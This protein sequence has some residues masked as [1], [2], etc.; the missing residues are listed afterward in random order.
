M[1]PRLAPLALLVSIQ[2]LFSAPP[3]RAGDSRPL[4]V[5]DL[6][7]LKDV[8]D[9]RLSPD[10]R[11]VAFTVTSLDADKDRANADVWLAPLG[12]GD[13]VRLT[14]GDRSETNPRFSPDGKWIAFLATRPEKKDGEETSQV[15]LLPR[16]GGEATRLTEFPGGVSDF[17]WSPDSQKLV[18]VVGDADSDPPATGADGEKKQKPI[19]TRRLQFKR[20]T[21]GYLKESRSHLRVFDVEKR[22]SFALTAGAFDD[23]SPAWS[24]DGTR[25]AFVSNRTLPDA[26]R[27]QDTN[28][29]LVRAA[30]GE[31]PRRLTTWP[32]EDRQPSFSPDGKSIVYVQ[33]SDPKD[34]W[35]GA[36]VVAVV[37]A[38]GGAPR[39]LTSSLDRNVLQPRFTPDG[40]SVLFLLEDGGNQHLARVPIEGGSV[41]RVVGGERETSA[42]DVAKDGA[43]VVLESSPG[44]PAEVSAVEGAGLRRLSHVNDEVLKGIR[45]GE[46]QRLRVKSRDGTPVDGFLVLPPDYKVG[47]KEPTILRIHGGPASQYST[48]FEME[49]QVLAGRGYAVVAANPRG[50][51]GYGTSFSRALWAEWGNPDFEDVMAALDQAIAQGVADPDR[52]GVGGWSYGGILTNYVITK[53]D[54]FKAA[55]SGAS[56]SN[57]LA[58]YGTDHYQYEYEVELGLPWKDRERWL[59]LS[60]PFFDVEK[61]NAPTLF[62]CGEKDMNV[63]LLN[64]E[65]MYQAVRRVG[66]VDTELVIYPGEWHGLK[67]PSFRKDRYE[68]YLAWYDHYLKPRSTVVP[69]TQAE[70]VSK[71][72]MALLSPPPPAEAKVRLEK[73]LE[74]ARVAF[75]QKPDDVEALLRVGRRTA[76][77]GRY[78]EAAEIYSRGLAAHP[79]DPRLLRHRGPGTSRCGTTRRPKPISRGRPSS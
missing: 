69:G 32:G 37:P 16:A 3:A 14:T 6:F 33:G 10:G 8:D 70:T 72:G 17:A 77:L 56:I 25:V 5:D 7:R 74:E 78:R 49:W 13:A 75:L 38:D 64:T 34:L 63:P 71:L 22:T 66:K 52:L 12:G 59:K 73:D 39:P 68:R 2:T 11:A 29:F 60:T 54:R 65:Q 50:S 40:R 20:D 24:P 35:Y 45:L 58:G 55:I 67:R 41:E 1:G 79:D 23:E 19:V 53:S 36:S 28:L 42:F 27:S 48:G 47:T 31:V 15:F 4:Q 62:V 57:Y 18:L 76:A 44:Q 61:I 51:T 26:D 30:P 43:I 9:P 21:V 46:V